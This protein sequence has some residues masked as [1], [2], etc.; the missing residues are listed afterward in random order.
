M[1]YD[2]LLRAIR[3]ERDECDAC[4]VCM[5]AKSVEYNRLQIMYYAFQGYQIFDHSY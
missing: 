4:I 2:K 1:I 5:S 3:V